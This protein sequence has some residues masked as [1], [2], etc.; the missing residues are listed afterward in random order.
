MFRPEL[1]TAT[2]SEDGAYI[3]I[4]FKIP[5]RDAAVSLNHLRR[6][7]ESLQG[8]RDDVRRQIVTICSEYAW[9]HDGSWG[10]LLQ[11]L[12]RECARCEG[13]EAARR[14]FGALATKSYSIKDREEDV[15]FMYEAMNRPSVPE[16]VD[17][18]IDI[19]RFLPHD[20]RLGSK[21][22][23]PGAMTKY[24]KKVLKRYRRPASR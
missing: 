1:S 5:P 14:F 15:V 13:P 16:F 24:V 2:W 23:I 21:T 8:T 9:R 17:T 6:F 7:G 10:E 11:S 3:S 12:F 18:L 19:N 20:R 4:T 22:I